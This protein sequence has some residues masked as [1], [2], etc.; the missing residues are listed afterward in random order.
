ML[1]PKILKNVIYRL[2][3]PNWGADLASQN[4]GSVFSMKIALAMF[5]SVN[6]F[7]P[8]HGFIILHGGK[9]IC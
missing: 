1:I 7:V 2:W 4:V 5:A 3:Q 8:W 6:E 9:I